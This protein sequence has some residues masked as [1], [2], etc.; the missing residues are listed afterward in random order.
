MLTILLTNDD[1][2]DAPG[3]NILAEK[4]WAVAN[5]VVVAPNTDFSGASHSLTLTRPL[6]V[7][8]LNNGFYSVNGTPTD[9]VHL[10]IT[11]LLDTMPDMVI[12]GINTCPNLGD[13][14]LYSGTVAG[15]MEGRFLGYPSIAVSSAGKE[16]ANYEC[17]ADVTVELV[18]KLQTHPLP[19]DTVLNVNIPDVPYAELKGW[20]VTALGKRHNAQPLIKQK[21][22]RGHDTYWIGLPSEHFHPAENTDFQA[23]EEGFVSI[24]PLHADLTRYASISSL[25]EWAAKTN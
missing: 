17:A 24:T 5:V 12:S 19:A 14:V 9:C 6:R 3:L 18:K 11:G 2:V 8:K 13:D 10:A 22:P 4:L 21:D 7:A 25:A 20:R 16:I 23:I 1:G 15:A